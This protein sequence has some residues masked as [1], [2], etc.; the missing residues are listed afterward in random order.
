MILARGATVP[1]ECSFY[2]VTGDNAHGLWHGRRLDPGQ[3][4]VHGPGGQ[5][6]H[7]TARRGN[8]RGLTL[9]DGEFHRAVRILR[10]DI[11]ELQLPSW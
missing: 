9:T 3:L 4:V 8:A 10:P 1:G 7:L 6:D 2:T 5:T 11:G